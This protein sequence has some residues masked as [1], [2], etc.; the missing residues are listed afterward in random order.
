MN[1]STA[2]LPRPK[3]TGDPL[4]ADHRVAGHDA[5]G[6]LQRR[7]HRRARLDLARRPVHRRLPDNQ[8]VV[9]RPGAEQ[10]Q[11]PPPTGPIARAAQRQAVDANDPPAGVGGGYL[12]EPA[13]KGALKGGRV[14]GGDG[15]AEGAVRG[16]ASGNRDE[17]A[18]PRLHGP[19]DRLSLNPGIRPAANSAAG[20]GDDVDPAVDLGAIHAGVGD[21]GEQP[22]KTPTGD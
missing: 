2:C 10:V 21:R 14:D 17:Q 19:P 5:A 4:L 22:T 11:R 15:V 3:R 9:D 7:Q 20:T 12:L 16:D 13:Q 1:T 8:D 18:P 6:R